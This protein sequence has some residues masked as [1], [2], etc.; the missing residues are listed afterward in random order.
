[1]SRIGPRA[2]LIDLQIKEIVEEEFKEIAE[3]KFEEDEESINSSFT[4]LYRESFNKSD[5][6]LG[7]IDHDPSIRVKT[8]N[9]DYQ[10]D[11]AISFYSYNV[12]NGDD[13]TISFPVT[14]V[15][16]SKAF[17]RESKFT[18]DIMNPC[19]LPSETYTSPKPAPSLKILRTLN[20]LRKRIIDEMKF[21][22]AS[23]PHLPGD[24]IRS[25]VNIVRRIERES[26]FDG[27]IP[28]DKISQLFL[29]FFRLELTEDECY[30]LKLSYEYMNSNIIYSDNLVSLLRNELLSP[31]HKEL[32]DIIFDICDEGNN[33]YVTEEDIGHTLKS[34]DGTPHLLNSINTKDIPAVF[35]EG[36]KSYSSNQDAFSLSDFYEYFRDVQSELKDNTKFEALIREMWGI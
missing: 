11:D 32:V 27:Q 13:K 9:A 30:A 36:L 22:N 18:A 4:T 19:L 33:G 14:S 8:F 7:M 2:K 21:S 16:G 34:V 28:L 26:T 23:K 25:G 6:K 17:Y 10:T 5:V 24:N 35:V 31:R 1:M 29:N 3:Q 15:C 20:I 12:D